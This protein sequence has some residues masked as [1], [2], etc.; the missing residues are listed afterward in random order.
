[1]L[2][3]F[4]GGRYSIYSIAFTITFTIAFTI[5]FTIPFTAFPFI[6]LLAQFT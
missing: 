2:P 4:A 5:A 1:M 3:I 6:R